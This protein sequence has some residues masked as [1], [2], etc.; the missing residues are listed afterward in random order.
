MIFCRRRVAR[1]LLAKT[2][3]KEGIVFLC[4]SARCHN[5]VTSKHSDGGR[6]R[7]GNVLFELSRIV[8][9]KR[10]IRF[11]SMGDRGFDLCIYIFDA[12]PPR[13]CLESDIELK[14]CNF[15]QNTKLIRM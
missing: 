4:F 9:R 6:G 2:E 15:L 8:V 11:K 5:K 10:G 12:S 14:V 3:R 13:C 7:G 1:C